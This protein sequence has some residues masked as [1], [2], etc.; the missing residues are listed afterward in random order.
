MTT[1]ARTIS[2][3]FPAASPQLEILKQLAMFC[4][5]GMLVWLLMETYGLN[6]SLGFF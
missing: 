3:A 6:L 2:R 1:L 5:A 4:G